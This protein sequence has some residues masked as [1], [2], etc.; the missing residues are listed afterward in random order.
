MQNR[1]ADG[2]LNLSEEI[3]LYLFSYLTD[4]KDLMI[5]A[6]VCKAQKRIT[7]DTALW[8]TVESATFWGKNNPSRE[9]YAALQN[10]IYIKKLAM[11]NGIQTE[12]VDAVISK[13][14]KNPVQNISITLLGNVGS[15]KDALFNL[16][17]SEEDLFTNPLTQQFAVFTKKITIEGHL[18][19]FMFISGMINLAL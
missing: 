6:Q 11:I 13:S 2:Y 15:H 12:A 10:A 18:N 19:Q 3:L 14:K 16:K 7:N 8:K 1:N 9:N 5:A 4:P 17:S